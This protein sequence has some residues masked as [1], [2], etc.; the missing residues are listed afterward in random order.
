MI[1]VLIVTASDRASTGGYEDLSGP[2]VERELR[3]ALGECRIERV[4]VP[5]D[6]DAL[7]DAFTRGTSFDVVLSTGGTGLGPR[8]R[9]PDVTRAH[10]ERDLPGIAEMLR[11][12]SRKTVP[13]AV[14][15]RA[16]SGVRG[17]TIYINLPGS[18]GGAADCARLVAPLLPHALSMLRGGSH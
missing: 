3:A 4:I 18:P 2:A 11:A 15:S 7:R 13:T 17:S 8:D 14:L 10:C 5:D 16:Y 12:E 1:S 9:T 6:D